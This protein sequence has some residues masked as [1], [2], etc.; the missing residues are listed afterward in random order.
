MNT[1]MPI[2]ISFKFDFQSFSPS[3]L[4]LSIPHPYT[5]QSISYLRPTLSPTLI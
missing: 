1:N 5:T 2:N 4:A 3:S